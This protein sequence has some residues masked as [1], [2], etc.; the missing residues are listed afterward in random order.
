MDGDADQAIALLERAIAVR[1]RYGEALNNLGLLRAERGEY[2][3]AVSAFQRATAVAPG[4][5]SW[6]NNLAN[7]LVEMRRFAEALAAYDAAISLATD[8]ADLWSNRVDGPARARARR[9]SRVSRWSVPSRSI[10][11]SSTRSA[12]W[13]SY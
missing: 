9:P 8:R 3:V 6:L 1:P 2:E 7:S 11:D 10:R 4:N 5:A 12:T 13:P